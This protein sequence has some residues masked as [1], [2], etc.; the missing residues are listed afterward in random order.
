MNRFNTTAICTVCGWSGKYFDAKHRTQNQLKERGVV[1]EKGFIK[2][3]YLKLLQERNGGS[4]D[5]VWCPKCD[6]FIETYYE[7]Q[8]TEGNN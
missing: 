3:P 5:L 1:N 2:D 4:I 6:T 8:E 7:K